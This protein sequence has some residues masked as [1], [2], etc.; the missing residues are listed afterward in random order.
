MRLEQGANAAL[1]RALTLQG[2]IA[3]FYGYYLR[4]FITKNEVILAG[5]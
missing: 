1:D 5:C 2:A 4:Y 3:V